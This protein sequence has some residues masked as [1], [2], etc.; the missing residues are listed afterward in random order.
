M[1]DRDYGD[2]GDRDF[3]G[4][5]EFGGG[6]GGLRGGRMAGRKCRDCDFVDFKDLQAMRRATT[7]QGKISSR[8]RTNACAKCQRL[9]A[10]AVKRARFMGILGFA[11]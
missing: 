9:T 7:P 6:F 2:R 8:K 5:G 11:G 4:D 1:R 3:G 10:S